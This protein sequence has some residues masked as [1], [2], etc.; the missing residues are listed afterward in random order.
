MLEKQAIDFQKYID[1]LEQDRREAEKRSLA[2]E[3]RLMDDAREHEQRSRKERKALEERLTANAVQMEKRLNA[4]IA[5]LTANAIKMEERL[6]A[7]S[8]KIKRKID[9]FVIADTK[10]A[11]RWFIGLNIA[12]IIGATTIIIAFVNLL[13]NG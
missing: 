13:A 5:Q 9:S 11:N 7:N 6:N 10:T 2:L 1:R 4:N 8:E 12:V 3:Q